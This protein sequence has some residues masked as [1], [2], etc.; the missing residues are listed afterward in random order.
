MVSGMLC[1]DSKE[2]ERCIARACIVFFRG[3]QRRHIKRRG[4]YPCWTLSAE[5]RRRMTEGMRA[6]RPQEFAQLYGTFK[7]P[8]PNECFEA[9]LEL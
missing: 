7:P 1:R 2:S 5:G 3:A 8:A 9:E 4:I 6:W